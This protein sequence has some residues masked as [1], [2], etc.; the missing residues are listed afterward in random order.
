MNYNY[1]SS[2]LKKMDIESI[3]HPMSCISMVKEVGPQVMMSG[4]GCYVKDS[5]GITYLSADAGLGATTLGFGQKALAKA[6]HSACDELGFY[7]TTINSSGRAQ[8]LLAE[9][10]LSYVPDYF[11]KIFFANSGSEAN[12]SALKIARFINAVQGKLKNVKF[13][14]VTFRTMVRH[15]RLSLSVVS[16]NST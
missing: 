15:Y 12:E 6:M 16:K 10:L 11:S 4:Q 2:E 14:H 5:D 7:Q 8:I 3:L 9:K 1:S 13:S